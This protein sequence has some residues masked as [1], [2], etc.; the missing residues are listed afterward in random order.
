MEE[1]PKCTSKNLF[2]RMKGVH[3][4]LY[5]GGCLKWLKWLSKKEAEIFEMKNDSQN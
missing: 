4:G 5:C 2:V 1:C 3:I